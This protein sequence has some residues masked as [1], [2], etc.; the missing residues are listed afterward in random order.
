MIYLKNCTL[1]VKQQSLKLK[2]TDNYSL[3]Q[4]SDNFLQQIYMIWC[5]QSFTDFA[6]GYPEESEIAGKFFCSKTIRNKFILN[7]LENEKIID[8]PQVAD[9][10]HHI[11]LYLNTHG[12][13][14]RWE[15]ASF[16]LVMGTNYIVHNNNKNKFFIN[17][18]GY[19]VS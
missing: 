9:K 13:S 7:L 12:N 2:M 17:I 5:Y 14:H 4:I 6:C 3:N 15:S 11:M 8:Q 19:T 1:G 16:L 18:E 10:F